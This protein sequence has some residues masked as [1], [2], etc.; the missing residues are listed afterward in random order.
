MHRPER[1]IPQHLFR[2]LPQFEFANT[3]Y[4]INSNHDECSLMVV[5]ADSLTPARNAC[6]C[7]DATLSHGPAWHL[8]IQIHRH[9]SHLDVNPTPIAGRPVF[10]PLSKDVGNA[11]CAQ[12]PCVM[13][14]L[15]SPRR[16]RLIGA[17]IPAR[18]KQ[19]TPNPKPLKPGEGQVHPTA[20]SL[21]LSHPPVHTNRLSI[22]SKV[23][24]LPHFGKSSGP[25]VKM[26]K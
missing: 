9:A 20:R 15:H 5:D 21:T 24:S 6:R 25:A 18:R 13:P 1:D 16:A 14:R 23:L 8:S 19:I 3:A 2:A 4:L 22:H 12:K 11:N 17:S 10:A 26:P 7:H